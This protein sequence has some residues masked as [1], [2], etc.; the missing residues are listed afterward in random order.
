MP[1][2]D[3]ANVKFLTLPGAVMKLPKRLCDKGII[4]LV[5]THEHIMP[6]AVRNKYAVDFGHIEA[7]LQAKVDALRVK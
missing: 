7:L 1:Y 3:S 4:S 2:W 5:D 6:E